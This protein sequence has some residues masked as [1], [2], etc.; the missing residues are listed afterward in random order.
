MSYAH[1]HE[2]T[3]TASMA[4]ADW[5]DPAPL[6]T[7]DGEEAG[8]ACGRRP[9]V[10]I[11]PPRHEFDT[12]NSSIVRWQVVLV[13]SHPSAL[14]AWPELDRLLEVLR[15]PL[16]VDEATPVSFQPPHGP[17]WPALSLTITTH[18]TH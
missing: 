16:D 14:E 7:L 1:A 5:G 15:V 10:L 6:V 2:L 18:H 8:S 17:A 13:A 4:L 3:T 11:Q 9:L 12:Y